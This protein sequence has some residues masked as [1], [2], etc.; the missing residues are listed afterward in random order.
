VSAA[1]QDGALPQKTRTIYDDLREAQERLGYLTPT[2]LKAVALSWDK[3]FC[4][5]HAIAS[6]YPHFRLK[7]PA[8]VEVRICRDFTCHLGGAAE[9]KTKLLTLQSERQD[10]CAPGTRCDLNVEDVSCLGRCHRYPAL[11]INDCYY[12]RISPD[13]AESEVRKALN[14]SLPPAENCAGSYPDS[15]PHLQTDPYQNRDEHYSALRE[16]AKS[17][18]I[19]LLKILGDARLQGMGGAG[20]L[21][22]IKWTTVKNTPGITKYIVC[23]ADESEPGTIKDREIL[24][25]LPHLVIEGMA[26]AGLCVGASKGY[27]YIRHEYQEQVAKLQDEIRRCYSLPHPVL[28]KRICDSN[29]S[30]DLEVFVS[31][32][33][34]ICGEESALL[35]AIEGRRAEPR[36]KPPIVATEGLWKKPTV[37]NNVETFAFA[38][39]IA[40]RHFADPASPI[41][42][43]PLKFIAVTGDVNKP[44]VYEVRMG[45]TYRDLIYKPEYGG[46]IPGGAELLGFAPSGPS[47]G[48]LPASM[49]DQT[50]SWSTKIEDVSDKPD[51]SEQEKE[52]TKHPI[53]GSAAIVVFSKERCMLEM[54]LN[55]AHFY[56]AESCGKCVPCRI[57]SQKMVEILDRWGQG[58]SLEKDLQLVYDLSHALRETSICPL[59][60]SVPVPIRSVLRYFPEEKRVHLDNRGPLRA[61]CEKRTP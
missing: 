15:L 29:F 41:A 54:A 53:V 25:H 32:G 42:P 11:V 19:D 24:T 55:A 22:G 37:V 38:A 23:N 50:L 58:R 43:W 2:D 4:D 3:P 6:Y 60:Q 59:G 40:A 31:P 47:F 56:A 30:F 39:A 49:V 8:K 17:P 44:G 9:L 36:N 51:K 45:T 35:E 57:G 27:I 52:K 20:F 33:G 34:Y 1:T 13:D 12:E 5:V 21:T 26:L 28:G 48:F 16:Y 10:Q 7:A 18:Q 46:G 14:D 61:C